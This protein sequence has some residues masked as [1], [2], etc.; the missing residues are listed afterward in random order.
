MQLENNRYKIQGID[1]EDLCKEFGT[2]LYVYDAAK[3]SEQVESM[4]DAFRNVNM[5][6][7]YAVNALYTTYKHFSR[8]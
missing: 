2:P 6:I 5:K 1:I 7:K 8:P 4:R 3:I